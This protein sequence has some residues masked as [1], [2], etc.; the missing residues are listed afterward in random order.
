MSWVNP[1]SFIEWIDSNLRVWII[2]IKGHGLTHDIIDRPHCRFKLLSTFVTHTLTRTVTNWGFDHFSLSQFENTA[3]QETLKS[4][5]EGSSG[6]SKL[7]T[8]FTIVLREMW[9][10]SVLSFVRPSVCQI[11]H[12]EM[13]SILWRGNF[14]S[15][16]SRV[17]QYLEVGKNWLWKLKSYQLFRYNF[18]I[19]SR[20]IIF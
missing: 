14:K 17:D 13:C 7:S 2:S 16:S 6:C 5:I 11:W 15:T 19:C 8:S 12:P 3:T 1:C 10:E 9:L 20:Q 18:S 4:T